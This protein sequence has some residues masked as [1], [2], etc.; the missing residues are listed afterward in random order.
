MKVFKFDD[1]VLLYCIYIFVGCKML[2]FGMLVMFL[3]FGGGW[4]LLVQEL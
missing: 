2:L 1:F 3:Y 4:E